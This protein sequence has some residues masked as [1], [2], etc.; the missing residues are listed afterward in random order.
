MKVDLNIIAP[1]AVVAAGVIFGYGVLSDKVDKIDSLVGLAD[2]NM[3]RVIVL[4]TK[5]DMLITPQM[6]IVPD[7]RAVGN[8]ERVRAI[9][10]GRLSAL[11]REVFPLNVQQKGNR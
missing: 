1:I 6:E 3:N 2:D 11:E 9:V 10:D 8:F 4:E 7:P 5:M